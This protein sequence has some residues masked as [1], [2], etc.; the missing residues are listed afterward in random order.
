MMNPY[1]PERIRFSSSSV[2]WY[3]LISGFRSYVAT[4]F[5]DGIRKRSSPGKDF[6]SPPLKKYVT[7]AYFSVSAILNCFRPLLLTTSP[8]MFVNFIELKADGCGILASYNFIVAKLQR[9]G[10][11]FL[12]N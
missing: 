2:T 5:G 12:L 11:T 3:A 7:W 9:D 10:I 8:R 6:S 4:S 1:S